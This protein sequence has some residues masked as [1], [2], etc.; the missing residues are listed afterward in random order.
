[1]I[2][3]FSD[4]PT[5]AQSRFRLAAKV[6]AIGLT[7]LLTW[8]AKTTWDKMKMQYFPPFPQS[9]GSFRQSWYSKHLAAM[10][11]EPLWSLPNQTN[12]FTFRFLWLRTFHHP[13][14]V[15][16][17]AKDYG[18]P[19]LLAKELDG[20]GGY[21]PGKLIVDRKSE[22]DSEAYKNLQAELK[23]GDFFHQP[24]DQNSLCCDGA[25]WIFEANDHGHYYVV[26]VWGGESLKNLGIMLL[27]AADLLPTAVY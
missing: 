4:A 7:L 14:C 6:L 3:L 21:S 5:K 9:V 12:N 17:N 11:E 8:G 24:Q 22:M 2:V 15:R 25:Q 16:V 23:A 18:V 1:M 19:V 27:K 10:H 20:A 13:I 26:D